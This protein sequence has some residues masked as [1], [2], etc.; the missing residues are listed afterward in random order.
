LSDLDIH[1]V[2][3]EEYS[4]IL[5]ATPWPWGGRT[6]PERLALF[7]QFG[8]PTIV[9]DAHSNDQIGGTFT[10]VVYRESA[11]NIDWMLIPQHKAH[12]EHP[13]LVL[14]DK[15]GIQEALEQEALTREQAVEVASDAVSFFWMIAAGN[16]KDLEG[17]LIHFHI[18]LSWMRDSISKVKYALVRKEPPYKRDWPEICNTL[19]KRFAALRHVE[20]HKVVPIHL[21]RSLVKSYPLWHLAAPCC[22][23]VTFGKVCLLSGM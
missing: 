11:Q 12:Q 13:S 2:V 10:H 20:S 23:S 9:Y 21:G 7:Q 4:E 14:F 18:L 3:A 5:C 8:M 6:T 1:V 22:V 16:A 17:D 19:A 15:V